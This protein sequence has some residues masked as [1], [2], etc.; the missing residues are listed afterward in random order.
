MR[1]GSPCRTLAT[2]I[3]R[4]PILLIIPNR[5]A[6]RRVVPVALCSEA[7]RYGG[8][9]VRSWLGN[10]GQLAAIQPRSLLVVFARQAA[11]KRSPPMPTLTPARRRDMIGI[12]EDPPPSQPE[13]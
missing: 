11:L 3:D 8:S 6:G 5:A 10:H 4:M 12:I 2:F 9:V 7:Y 1:R 13:K